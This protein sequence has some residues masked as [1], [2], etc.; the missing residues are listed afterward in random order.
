M[1]DFYPLI[2]GAVAQLPENTAAARRALYERVRGMLVKQLRSA[3]PEISATEIERELNAL[4]EAIDR[5]EDEAGPLPDAGRM[6][7]PTPAGPRPSMP[8]AAAR[9]TT[10]P[11]A[12]RRARAGGAKRIAIGIIVVAGA[13][14][15]AYFM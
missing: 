7:P 5:I 12:T 3:N 6:S 9:P 8:M 13:L 11:E 14:A 15:G 2:S 1:A 10:M 4:E